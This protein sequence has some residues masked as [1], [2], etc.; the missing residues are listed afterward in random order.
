MTVTE[1]QARAACRADG[2]N[3]NLMIAGKPAWQSYLKKV[4][5]ADVLPDA[6]SPE[7]IALMREI[8][9]LGSEIKLIEARIEIKVKKLTPLLRGKKVRYSGAIYIVGDYLQAWR[10]QISSRGRKITKDGRVGR[11]TWEIR[12]IRPES[13]E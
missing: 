2:V 12:G 13:F 8:H 9:A 4:N 3:P 11:G 7:A 5:A 6:I 10:G 1:E